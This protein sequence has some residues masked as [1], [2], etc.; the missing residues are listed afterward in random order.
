MWS[1]KRDCHAKSKPRRWAC[2]ETAD[3]Y[4]PIIDDRVFLPWFWKRDCAWASG[5][6]GRDNACVVPTV[7][8]RF[9]FKINIPWTWFGITTY[10]SNW[11]GRRDFLFRSTIYLQW[12]PHVIIHYPIY[13][14]SQKRFS[15][16]RA[17][18]DKIGGILS[19]IPPRSAGRRDPV[20]IL[21]FPFHL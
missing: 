2:L 5:I 13:N 4:D 1:W 15:A 7:P 20:F 16:G 19:I 21:K 14:I 3:L 11:Y 10:S 8:I 9:P 17:D 12:F 6:G 18:C